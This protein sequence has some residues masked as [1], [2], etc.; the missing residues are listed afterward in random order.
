MLD[1]FAVA[2]ALRQE[3]PEAFSTLTQ[4]HWR[5]ANTAKTT[6]YVW[7]SPMIVLDDQASSA[8]CALPTSCEG[9]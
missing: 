9:R 6:D 1:G 5:Y 2:D 3:D 8:K 4:V 7:H